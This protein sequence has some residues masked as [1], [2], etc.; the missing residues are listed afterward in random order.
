MLGQGF[1]Q[2]QDSRPRPKS[3]RRRTF[4]ARTR[5]K[6]VV[7]PNEPCPRQRACALRH[8]CDRSLEL[9][10]DSKRRRDPA[11]FDDLAAH[12]EGRQESR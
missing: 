2:H 12:G 1:R 9:R 5:S 7:E 6:I 11:K 3:Q 8:A 10:T 4:R